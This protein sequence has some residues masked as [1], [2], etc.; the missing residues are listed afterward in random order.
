MVKSSEMKIA[1]ENT[2]ATSK[3]HQSS[4]RIWTVRGGRHTQGKQRLRRLSRP[5][6]AGASSSEPSLAIR[7]LEPQGERQIEMEL[8]GNEK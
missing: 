8:T 3:E 4:G 1:K 5:L 7:P 6:T 2:A